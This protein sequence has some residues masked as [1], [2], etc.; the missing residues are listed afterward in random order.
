M[1]VKKGKVIIASS[2]A[3]SEYGIDAV[4][5]ARADIDLKKIKD[6]FERLA[7]NGNGNKSIYT[8]LL[9]TDQL[10][11]LESIELHSRRGS[12]WDTEDKVIL[13]CTLAGDYDDLL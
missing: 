10:E 9:Q 11:K 5:V 13:I 8:F 7:N 12:N 1:I 6:D 2:G 3:Y 4:F